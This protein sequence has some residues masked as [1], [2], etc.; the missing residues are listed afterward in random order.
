MMI[1]RNDRGSEYVCKLFDAVRSQISLVV[2]SDK[3]ISNIVSDF[4]DVDNFSVFDTNIDSLK[5]YSGYRD[6]KTITKLDE[7]ILVILERSDA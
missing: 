5:V 1:L 3:K 7:G 6:F 4:E 2:D